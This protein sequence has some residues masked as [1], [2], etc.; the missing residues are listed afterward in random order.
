VYVRE[1]VLL[2]IARRTAQFTPDAEIEPWFVDKRVKVKRV[3]TDNLT[4][5]RLELPM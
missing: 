5:V 4:I 2:V 3:L 1:A